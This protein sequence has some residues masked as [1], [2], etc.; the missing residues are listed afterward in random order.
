MEH[1]V[2]KLREKFKIQ[3]DKLNYLQFVKLIKCSLFQEVMKSMG[4]SQFI[5]TI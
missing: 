4:I 2:L 5:I 1:I 3:R